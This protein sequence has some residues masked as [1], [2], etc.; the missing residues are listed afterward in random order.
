MLNK[1]T[2]A[3]LLPTKELSDRWVE[4]L[5]ASRGEHDRV[6]RH[7]NFLFAHGWI[8]GLVDAG[9]LNVTVKPDLVEL[10]IAAKPEGRK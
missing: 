7:S 6:K 1:E 4:M 3:D 5:S 10:L 2:R 8:V 9:V